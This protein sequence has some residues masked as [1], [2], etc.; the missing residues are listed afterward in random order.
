MD[1]PV[2]DKNYL[3][4]FAHA[5][6]IQIT[7]YPEKWNIF[8]TD[9]DGNTQHLQRVFRDKKEALKYLYAQLFPQN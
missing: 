7:S 9:I 1:K 4:D 6:E 3:I 2:D 8:V 5:V